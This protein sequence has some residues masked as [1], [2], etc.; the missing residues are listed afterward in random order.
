MANWLF[1]HN[2]RWN[3]DYGE[4]ES[5]EKLKYRIRA[6]LTGLKISHQEAAVYNFLIGAYVLSESRTAS[7]SLSSLFPSEIG[8]VE[9][10][11]RLQAAFE[12]YEMRGDSAAWKKLCEAVELC[13]SLSKNLNVGFRKS[14][15]KQF[16]ILWR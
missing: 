3:I 15:K 6:C 14:E 16:Y 4:E 10:V 2:K 12:L 9:F 7:T 11:T 1:D 5:F 13:L 8:I